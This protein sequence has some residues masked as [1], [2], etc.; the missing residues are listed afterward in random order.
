MMD[1]LGRKFTGAAIAVVLIAAILGALVEGEIDPATKNASPA[2]LD[3]AKTSNW[4]CTLEEQAQPI[5]IGLSSAPNS[6]FRGTNVL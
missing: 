4:T 6:S 3:K 1:Q 2:S 5:R